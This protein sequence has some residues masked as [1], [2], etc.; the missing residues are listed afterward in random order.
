M[1]SVL[2]SEIFSAYC[3]GL[4]LKMPISSRKFSSSD[5]A[6]RFKIRARSECELDLCSEASLGGV[7]GGV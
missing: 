1:N 7:D 6:R 4:A 2:R 3:S 5:F